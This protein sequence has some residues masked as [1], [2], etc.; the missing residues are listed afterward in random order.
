MPKYIPNAKRYKYPLP[1]H[2]LDQLPELIPH[3]P[4]SWIHWLY[5]YL[6]STNSL[7]AKIHV[8]FSSGKHITIAD[9]KEMLY[10]WQNGF[11]GTAQLSRSE[12]TW[13]QRTLTRLGL[14]ESSTALEHVTEKRRLQRLEFKRERAGFEAIKLNLRCQ[15]VA[16]TEILRQER[17]FLKSL[18]E[19]EV[20]Q[21]KESEDVQLRSSDIELFNDDNQLMEL[22]VLELM[23]VEAIFLTFALPVLDM[24]PMTLVRSLLGDNPSYN[25]IHD[26]CIM[27]VAYHH[28]RSHGWCVRSGIKFGCHYLLYKRGPPFQHAEYG[29]MVLN[30]DDSFDYTWYSSAARVV[31]GAKK[32]FILCYIELQKPK[33]EILRLWQNGQFAAV[34]SSYKVGEILYRRWVPGKNRD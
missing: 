21:L 13:K 18:R 12:P 30:S 15:G 11:F 32:S 10:L 20:V 9:P 6:S 2:P 22:E 7:P 8:E 28:Y 14:E 19:R 26:L 25:N 16:E 29:I 33:D 3:N 17:E 24:S 5:C 4:V 27:Y 1:I 31:G 23:P 34:F